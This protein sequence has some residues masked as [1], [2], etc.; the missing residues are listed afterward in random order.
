MMEAFST[1]AASRRGQEALICRTA[2]NGSLTRLTYSQLLEGIEALAQG[3]WRLGIRKGDAVAAL[4]SPGPDF[5]H[6]FFAVAQ[7]G[8]VFVPLSPQ[9]RCRGLSAVLQDAEPVALI[10]ETAARHFWPGESA[11]GVQWSTRTSPLAL[12]RGP[13]LLRISS[14]LGEAPASSM[15]PGSKPATAPGS[16]YSEATNSYGRTPMTALTWPG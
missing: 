6:V 15:S 11:A 13:R 7:V 1:V 16:L 3:L 8:A 2:G 10:S 12:T 4:L 9:V 14:R 5:V